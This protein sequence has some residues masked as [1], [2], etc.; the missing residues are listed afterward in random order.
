M[1]PVHW[2]GVWR[3]PHRTS[4]VL[5][6]ARVSSAA[7]VS[8]RIVPE[9]PEILETMPL[10]LHRVGLPCTSYYRERFRQALQAQTGP[11]QSPELTRGSVDCGQAR[12]LS[13]LYQEYSRRTARA[14]LLSRQKGLAARQFR[15]GPMVSPREAFRNALLY[16]VTAN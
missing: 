7:G 11:C 10:V 5:H 8:P 6:S 3:P 16:I 2:A 12:R 15:P 13:R 4:R 1:F 9:I 14:R